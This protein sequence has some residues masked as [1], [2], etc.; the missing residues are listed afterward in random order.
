M[1]TRRELWRDT[2]SP[3]WWWAV[4]NL[5]WAGVSY[6][7]RFDWKLFVGGMAIITLFLGMEAAFR[8]IRRREQACEVQVA[9]AKKDAEKEWGKKL[10]E[11][12][13]KQAEAQAADDEREIP[14]VID[15]MRDVSNEERKRAGIINRNVRENENWYVGKL[16]HRREQLVR[17]AYKEWKKDN[18]R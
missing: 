17:K 4:G 12:K 9:S 14:N 18:L 7:L 1:V 10:E 8:I 3:F 2:F 16:P 13:K 11:I 15:E 6:L 5:V